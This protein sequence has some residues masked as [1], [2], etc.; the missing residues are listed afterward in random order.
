MIN[1]NI[2]HMYREH[3][4]PELNNIKAQVQKILKTKG[5]TVTKHMSSCYFVQAQRS[6]HT[7]ERYIKHH[8]YVTS[9]LCLFM[10]VELNILSNLNVFS[11]SLNL[12]QG[13]LNF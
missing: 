10:N 13:R 5:E 8:C 11:L 12:K 1:I 2:Q 9:F 3:A 6:I 4:E 7:H